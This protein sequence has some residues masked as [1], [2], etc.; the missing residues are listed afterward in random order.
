MIFHSL[1][2]LQAFLIQWLSNN[3]PHLLINRRPLA[4]AIFATVA[5]TVL[6]QPRICLFNPKAHNYVCPQLGNE[7]YRFRLQ[8]PESKMERNKTNKTN[9]TYK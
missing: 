4:H 1:Q 3:R 2:T 9:N 6:I 8:G 7:F 5:S